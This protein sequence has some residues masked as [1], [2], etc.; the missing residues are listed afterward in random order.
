MKMKEPKSA[1]GRSLLTIAMLLTTCLP[2]L[3]QYKDNLGGNWSNP[4]SATI[5]NIIMDRYARRRLEK[6]LAAKRPNSR[7]T[8]GSQP[9]AA[10]PPPPNFND[11]AVR[12]R[13]TGTQ[14]KTREIANL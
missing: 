8:T 11:A 12:F 10:S 9:P 7:S 4:A 6:N 1:I 5:T 3:A 13:S 14:L 2:V